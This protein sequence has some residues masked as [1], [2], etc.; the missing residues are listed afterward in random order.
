MKPQNM[1]ASSF[2]SVKHETD[3]LRISSS[4]LEGTASTTVNVIIS[5]LR[6]PLIAV[7]TVHQYRDWPY[8]SLLSTTRRCANT[9]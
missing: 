1:R 9:V 8:F 2:T 7:T 5:T 6:P 3:R 4:E